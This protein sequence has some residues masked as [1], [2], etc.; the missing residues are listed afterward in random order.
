MN[1]GGSIPFIAP[2]VFSKLMILLAGS[3]AVVY[4][5]SQLYRQLPHIPGMALIL[6]A[7]LGAMLLDGLL[8]QGF[9][10]LNLLLPQRVILPPTLLA[11]VLVRSA[12][13]I[14]FSIA[15]SL[16]GH[17]K[18]L[19]TDELSAGRRFSLVDFITYRKQY[20]IARNI[21]ITDEL[22]G[23]YNRRHF[24]ETLPREVE[25]AKRYN[26]PLSLAFIDIDFFKQFNDTYGHSAGDAVLG[27]VAG[28]LTHN[29][30]DIDTI[31][32][33]G[34]EEFVILLPTTSKSGAIIA[35]NKLRERVSQIDLSRFSGPIKSVTISVGLAICPEETSSAEDLMKIADDRL[36]AAK[37]AGRDRVVSTGNGTAGIKLAK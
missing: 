21:A 33:Y 2:I 14:W 8:I 32:R 25:R 20:E 23:L 17:F 34:G 7:I 22:T 6:I 10:P 15:L 24:N 37:E 13:A 16:M 19:R 4:I 3:I 11:N 26:Q 30:R 27:D 9:G 5:H 18:G 1:I 31:F 28:V 36:Y 35:M 12:I 29:S